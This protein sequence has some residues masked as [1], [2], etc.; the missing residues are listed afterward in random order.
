MTLAILGAMPEEI[1]PILNFFKNYESVEYGNNTYYKT[2][3]KGLDLVIAYSKIG[4][5]NAALTATVLIEKF[6]S[7]K[8]L[9]SGVAGA[10]NK[11]LR[12]GDILYATSLAQHD[13]DITAFG[14][15]YGFVPGGSVYVKSD[16][17]LNKIAKS[18]AKDLD[19]KL[20][21]GII[22]TGDQFVC[23]EEKKS[24]IKKIFNADAIEMEGAAV[25]AVC[26][27]L[28]IPF[29][30][31]RAISDG[32]G[33]DAQFDFDTFLNKSA[34]QSAKFLIKILDKIS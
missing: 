30:V 3:Y 2:T 6:K 19:I 15:D 14:H 31:L 13:L 17:R 26:D 21:S 18:V 11:D 29:F 28:N 33:M 27:S 34:K 16:E 32:A 4:K 22:A 23:D 9:F 25:A 20:H 8:L 10:V 12:I 1:E 24:W 5:V 7:Q